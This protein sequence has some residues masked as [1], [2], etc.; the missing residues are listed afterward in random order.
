M[1]LQVWHVDMASNTSVKAFADR[2]TTELLRI[3]GFVAN[4]GIMV[5]QWSLVEGVE[6]SITVNVI[7][8]LLL[9][10]LMMPKLHECARMYSINPALIFI[11]SVLGY[12]AGAEIDKLR[13]GGILD[14]LS[15]QKN[16]DMDAR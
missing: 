11:V 8:T 2:A 9:G 3:D 14:K 15:E 13:S 12:T 10:V 7:N 5:D 16:A 6:S 1:N 4:A